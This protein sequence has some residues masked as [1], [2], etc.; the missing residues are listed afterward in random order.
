M[1]IFI[2]TQRGR[3][4]NLD[5]VLQLRYGTDVRRDSL[6]YSIYAD[7][8]V[9]AEDMLILGEYDSEEE[10]QQTLET[11]MSSFCHWLDTDGSVGVYSL[12]KEETK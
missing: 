2:K 8:D 9:V 4:V 12:C 7:M 10:A 1:R 11:M 6:V 3:F 5:C